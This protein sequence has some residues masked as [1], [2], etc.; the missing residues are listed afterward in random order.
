MILGIGV[1]GIAVLLV[2]SATA[3]HNTC[4]NELM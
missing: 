1:L 4:L 3:V 2:A